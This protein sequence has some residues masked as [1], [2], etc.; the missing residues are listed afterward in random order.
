[1]MS[2]DF[3]RK[4]YNCYFTPKRVWYR[5]KI[6]KYNGVSEENKR[7]LLNYY[8]TGVI[9][10]KGEIE[11]DTGK[12]SLPFCVYLHGIQQRRGEAGSSFCACVKWT[13]FCC[14]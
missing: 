5:N 2:T 11:A 13:V 9:L 10:G 12:W 14:V 3:W 6:N 1:M 8:F 4:K 7:L